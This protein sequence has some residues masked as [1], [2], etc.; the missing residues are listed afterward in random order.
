MKT[1]FT[2]VVVFCLAVSFLFSQES[3][4]TPAPKEFTKA[5]VLA[6]KNI[7][8][9]LAAVNPATDYSKYTV[10]SFELST[11]VAS[12]AGE[13]T[14]TSE[15]GPGGTWS[16]KQKQMLEKAQQGNVYSVQNIRA[17]EPGKKGVQNLS[18]FSFIIKD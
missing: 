10:R 11:A 2:S 16:E 8:D 12:D 15:L 18:G 4:K 17:I 14:K 9:F 13:K 7:L 6:H 1:F 5:E 3:K